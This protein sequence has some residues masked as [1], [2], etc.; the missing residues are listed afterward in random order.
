MKFPTNG[1]LYSGMLHSKGAYS[2]AIKIECY[3]PIA[4]VTTYKYLGIYSRCVKITIF[5]IADHN[6]LVSTRWSTC[7][8]IIMNLR[9]HCLLFQ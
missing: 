7:S 6:Q 3:P 5:F 4:L 8:D 2:Y 9:Y 1:A